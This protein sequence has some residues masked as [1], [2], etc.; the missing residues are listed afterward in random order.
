MVAIGR[1][2][3]AIVA[4]AGLLL[5]ASAQDI[6]LQARPA[7]VLDVDGP[8]G[9]ATSEYIRKGLEAALERQA[10]L[11]VLRLD[12]PG[13]LVAAMQ[14]IVQQILASSIPVVTFVAPGG[15]RAASAGTYIL[16][17]SHLAAMAPGT[18]VGAATP[19]SLGGRSQPLEG[20]GA[21]KSDP[22]KDLA[23]PDT[24]TV[25]TIND[26]VAYIR[27][28]A[29]IQ[30]RNAEWAERAVREA[31]SLPAAEALE[32]QVIEIVAP[33]LDT[34]LAAA[35]G[36]V[37]TVGG[38]AVT[39]RTNGIELVAIPPDWRARL[40]AFLAD[41]NLAYIL[42]L[43]G[44]YGIIFEFVSP[45]GFGP[46]VV[47]AICLVL[48]LFS[49][50]MLPLNYAGIG[51]LLLGVALM[52]AEAFVPSFGA[53]GIGG[54][55]AF[56]L[57]SVFMFKEVPGFELSLGVV[58]AAMVASAAL[59]ILALAAVFRAH[60]RRVSSGDPALLGASGEVIAWSDR[61][62]WIHIHGERWQ[63]R[64]T[65]S[66]APGTPVRVLARDGLVLTVE[67]KPPSASEGDP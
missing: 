58:A 33:D 48:A 10:S 53:L 49:L 24:M 12:T 25:K 37:V 21:G 44:I 13:G 45:G 42:L 65:T 54:L 34:L 62:G 63:A 28:L 32:Q 30:G 64:A 43:I 27:A 5:A 51:L 36:R 23:R 61:S 9:P 57:G 8:I 14:D 40:L 55:V 66:L 39:L 29:A 17:A 6:G 16:Y 46:G 19:V 41:P 20:N 67:P 11:V 26:A 52:V 15:A 2:A 60:R 3:A 22:E 56:G 59:L 35:N 50:N 4:L 47:G 18:N 1:V 31:A 38:E 7:I